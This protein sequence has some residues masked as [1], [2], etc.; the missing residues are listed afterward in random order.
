MRNLLATGA[1][2]LRAD[3]ADLQQQINGLTARM[4]ERLGKFDDISNQTKELEGLVVDE[5]GG[6]PGGGRTD[7]ESCNGCAGV[8]AGVGVGVGVGIHM[9]GWVPECQ[10]GPFLFDIKDI[11][12]YSYTLQ[13]S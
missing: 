12:L 3:L 7:F 6:W 9:W 8:G 10:G 2:S 1:A 5:V 11:I 13:N 4:A